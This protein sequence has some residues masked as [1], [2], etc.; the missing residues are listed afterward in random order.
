MGKLP[1]SGL[2]ELQSLLLQYRRNMRFLFP[3]LLAT[4][5]CHSVLVRGDRDD[6]DDDDDRDVAIQGVGS[7]EIE[8]E[9]KQKLFNVSGTGDKTTEAF[10]LKLEGKSDK[11]LFSMKLEVEEKK[12]G[13]ELETELSFKVELLEIIEY[14]PT[15]P[16]QPFNSSL[17]PVQSYVIGGGSPSGFHPFTVEDLNVSGVPIKRFTATTRDGVFAIVGDVPTAT[18]ALSNGRRFTPDSVKINFDVKN[19]PYASSG[20]SSLAIFAKVKT[21]VESEE[22]EG[23]DEDGNEHDDEDSLVMKASPSSTKHG[24]LVWNK[25]VEIN[26]ASTTPVVTSIKKQDIGGGETEVKLWWSFPGATKP[27][28]L[29]W[30]PTIGA[31][32]TGPSATSGVVAV[33]PSRGVLGFALVFAFL[34]M[35]YY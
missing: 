25:T 21:E 4:L 6:D 32:T 14:S 5:L 28:R 31:G 18:I 24:F 23:K 35:H 10:K 20:N 2:Q 29:F 30:D 8:I 7:T 1:I 13:A 3:M 26:G 12:N 17:T 22:E 11:A 27:N 15:H 16:S 34:Q 9:S 33:L 19:F